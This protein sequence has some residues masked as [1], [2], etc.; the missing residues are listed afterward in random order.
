M[1][2]FGKIL[3]IALSIALVIACSTAYKAKPLPFRAAESYSNAKEVAGAWV[4]AQ[5]YA[6]KEHAEQAFGFDVRG[7]GMLPVQVVFDNRGDHPIK[8]NPGQTFLEDNEG[9][10]WPILEREIA[11]DRATKYAQSKQIVSEGVYHG[12]LGAAAGAIIG[13]AVGIV[14][15]ANVGAALGKGAALGGAAG[16]TIGG[17][18]GYASGEARKEIINDL[19]E[20]TLENVPVQPKTIA[21]G[22][23]FFPG[24]ASSAK[25]LRLQ[26]MEE[27]TG[28]V[29][30]LNMAL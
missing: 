8:I 17:T 18:K 19:R 9:N 23:L 13:A 3:A 14:T 1:R 7:A 10:L 11:Y 2:N 15:G 30:V 16:A 21:H 12:A 20:K 4:G 5:A 6:D 27:D 25:N 22:F 26:I 24:E 28:K 29:D